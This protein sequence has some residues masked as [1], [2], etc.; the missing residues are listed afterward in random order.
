MTMKRNLLGLMFCMI[1]LN[2]AFSQVAG[3]ELK[4]RNQLLYDSA[5]TGIRIYPGQW[6]PHFGTEHIAW[7]KPPWPGNEY[8]WM[9]FPEAI[10][11]EEALL[12]LSHINPLFPSRNPALPAVSWENSGT[13]IRYER[14]LPGGIRFGGELSVKDETTVCMEIWIHNGTDRILKDIKMQ[15]CAYLHA[16]SEFKE[17]TN[18]NKLVHVPGYGW[19]SIEEALECKVKDGR[20]KVGWRGGPNVSDLPVIAVI[21]GNGDH[22]VAMTWKDHTYS[23]IGNPQHPCF[24]ADPYM[25]DLEPGE[26]G[27]IEGEMVFFEGTIEEFDKSLNR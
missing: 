8:I 25:D 1:C 15:T 2:A 20:Y 22:L 13:G 10:F 17:H 27:I 12:F 26:T 21:S 23:F 5:V 11:S 3:Q 18:G 14:G 7:I 24:H 9:D 19:K 6:R 4:E 16:I